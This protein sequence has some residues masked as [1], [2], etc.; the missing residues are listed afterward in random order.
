[1]TKKKLLEILN[2]CFFTGYDGAEEAYRDFDT[3]QAADDILAALEVEQM[4][5]RIRKPSDA[6]T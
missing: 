3:D 4:E 6:A 1:M 2:E 5:A